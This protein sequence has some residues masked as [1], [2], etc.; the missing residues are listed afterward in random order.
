[1]KKHVIIESDTPNKTRVIY[2][3]GTVL[4]KLLDK[5]ETTQYKVHKDLKIPMS[6]LSN[7]LHLRRDLSRAQ[8]IMI[9][10]YFK[11]SVAV[12]FKEC[13]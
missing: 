1:M 11:V 7:I 9:C 6:T 4:R 10:K 2:G 13:K 5:H 12:F 8:I 3:D